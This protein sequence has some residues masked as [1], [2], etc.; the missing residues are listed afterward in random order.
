MHLWILMPARK[1]HSA[2]PSQVR[3]DHAELFL[4][5]RLCH[6]HAAWPWRSHRLR[7]APSSALNRGS[8]THPPSR[9][10]QAHEG[11]YCRGIG[12]KHSA[13]A[14]RRHQWRSRFPGVE[15]Y[16]QSRVD[17]STSRIGR[18]SLRRRQQVMAHRS[19][20]AGS[21]DCSGH[22]ERSDKLTDHFSGLIASGA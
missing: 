20:S 6:C 19:I 17:Q 4:F 14:D 7:S 8:K 5:A 22:A 16:L 11:I 15:H 1:Y 21:D 18:R 9:K 3:P 10:S 2:Q 12:R 13:M